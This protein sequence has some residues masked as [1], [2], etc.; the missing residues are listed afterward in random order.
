MSRRDAMQL[1]LIPTK[2]GKK[3]DRSALEIAMAGDTARVRGVAAKRS[4]K[5]F[6]AMVVAA[7]T[8]YRE[9]AEA[10]ITQCHPATVG[11]PGHMM[12]RDPSDVDFVGTVWRIGAQTS[13]GCAVAFDAKVVEG[14]HFMLADKRP[15]VQAKNERQCR[16]LVDFTAC[17]GLGFY[18]LHSWELEGSWIVRGLDRLLTGERITLWERVERGGAIVHRAPFLP[19]ATV[20]DIARGLPTVQWLHLLRNTVEMAA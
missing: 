12:F 5:A 4:G 9:R 13:A 17:G 16:F 19:D 11:P 6:E 2:K 10:A 1:G 7:N 8:W 14:H 15:K 20:Q 18:L 3:R